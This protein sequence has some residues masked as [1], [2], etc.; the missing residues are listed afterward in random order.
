MR[1]GLYA[2]GCMWM[3]F[4]DLVTLVDHDAPIT[5]RRKVV[6]ILERYMGRGLL[7]LI[8][9]FYVEWMNTFDGRK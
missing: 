6:A 7:A 8:E 2:S 1:G 5:S 9:E 3:P 4:S